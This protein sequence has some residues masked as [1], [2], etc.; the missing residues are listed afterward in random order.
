MN[1]IVSSE[2]TKH[3]DGNAGRALDMLGNG[4]TP[5]ACAQALGISES[6]VSQLLSDEEFSKQVTAKRFTNLQ[7]HAE[8]DNSYDELE[9]KLL[10][11][12]SDLLPFMHKPMEVLRALQIING[13]KRR[14]A[15]STQDNVTVHSTIVTL[16]LP[17]MIQNKFIKN[18]NN[19]V[20]SAGDQ[21]L[22]TIDSSQLSA[23]LLQ[24]VQNGNDTKAIG[25]PKEASS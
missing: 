9:D 10:T 14:S 2:V 17:Q 5:A 13:A 22:V 15:G 24:G 11:K 12:M 25:V 7:K 3:Y 8:R 4:L 20:I 21:E 6:Y 1:A 18:S 16:Q 23:K 19:Q